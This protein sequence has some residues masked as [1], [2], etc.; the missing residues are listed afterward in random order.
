MSQ[1]SAVEWIAA[2]Q[3]GRGIAAAD[4]VLAPEGE[5]SD[6]TTVQPPESPEEGVAP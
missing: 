5:V 1:A 4:Y 3:K 6:G 2:E